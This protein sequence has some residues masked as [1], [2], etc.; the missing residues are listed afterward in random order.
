M[1]TIYMGEAVGSRL[2]S[3]GKHNQSGLVI[4]FRSRVLRVYTEIRS[5]YRK[6]AEKA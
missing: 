5:F 2:W 1:F 4:T 3:N 6:M